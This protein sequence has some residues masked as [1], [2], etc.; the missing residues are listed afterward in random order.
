VKLMVPGPAETWPDELLE[1]ARPTLPHYGDEFLKIWHNVNDSLKKIFATKADVLMLCGAGTAGTEMALSG[2]AKKKCLVVKGGMFADRM[3]EI[4]KLHRAEVIEI[5]IEPRSAVTP[6]AIAEALKKHPDAS[7]VCLVHSE[8]STGILAPIA[9]IGKIVAKTG[10]LFV[11]DAVSSLGSVDFK[12]DSWD[13]DICF[14][15]S[16]KALGCPPGLA[17]VAI[18]EKAMSVIKQNEKN[19]TGFYL[20]PLIWKW[21]ADNWQWHPYPTSQPTPVFAAMNKILTRL[22]ADGLD[23]HYKQQAKAASAMRKGCQAVGFELYPE[24]ESFATPTVTALIPPKGLD[25]EAFR[26]SILKDHDILIAGGFGPLRGQ[27]IRIGHMGP[28]IRT[29]YILA[30]LNAVETSAR[31]HGINCKIGCAIATAME[32]LA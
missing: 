22:I 26:Q 14:S 5:D 21:H 7:A 18:N 9:N 19:I 12:M 10:A 30:T 28:G 16:Q 6:Q 27:I 13:I 15:A 31:K 32:E 25:E 20:N 1:L 17:M 29:D 2:F 4:L 23:K 24:S 8:T 3:A 11:V